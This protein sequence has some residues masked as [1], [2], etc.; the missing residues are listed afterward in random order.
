M[1]SDSIWM[2]RIKWPRVSYLEKS[3]R[4]WFSSSIQH[5]QW[6][7]PGK[8]QVFL[9]II[10]VALHHGSPTTCESS[11]FPAHFHSTFYKKVGSSW[12]VRGT[13]MLMFARVRRPNSSY[14]FLQKNMISSVKLNSNCNG[15]AKTICTMFCATPNIREIAQGGQFTQ[16]LQ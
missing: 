6:K 9:T 1:K 12:K 15:A 8:L 10:E 4:K 16:T 11:N 2:T 3:R 7:Y 5:G 14:I 13:Q